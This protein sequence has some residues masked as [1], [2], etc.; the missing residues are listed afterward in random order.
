M[1]ILKLLGILFTVLLLGSCDPSETTIP[2]VQDT[3]VK[4]NVQQLPDS[5][6]K[7]TIYDPE[8]FDWQRPNL[9]IGLLSDGDLSDKTVVDIGAGTGF[10]SKR[11]APMAKKVI[12]LDIDQNFLN[13][14]DSIKVNELPADI[15]QRLET[16]LTPRDAPNLKNNEV[17]AVLIVNTFMFIDNKQDYLEK[18]KQA[19]KPGGRIVI[20]DFKRKRTGHGPL[21]RE[22]RLPLFEVED[23]FYEAGY[24]NIQAIDTELKYQYILVADR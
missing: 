1:D 7:E 10:F 12:A 13:I 19:V 14:I 11:L 16:R 20:V 17:D 18:L 6:E 23:L 8:R 21:P 15:Q 24:K 9:I 4:E 3:P 5:G 22:H 2:P